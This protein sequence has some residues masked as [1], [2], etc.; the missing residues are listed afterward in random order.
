MGQIDAQKLKKEI[1]VIEE[2]IEEIEAIPVE[3][4][5]EQNNL[6][7]DIL[8]ANIT[9]LYNKLERLNLQVDSQSS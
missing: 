5:T 2:D 9:N 3:K 6:L 8:K 1:H 4:R 7:L